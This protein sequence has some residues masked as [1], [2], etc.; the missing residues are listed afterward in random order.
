[1]LCQW[2][3]LNI[4]CAFF[5]LSI[6]GAMVHDKWSWAGQMW[7]FAACCRC[8]EERVAAPWDE[9]RWSW[10]HRNS[11]ICLCPGPGC[12]ST[13]LHAVVPYIFHC[14]RVAVS[15]C[16]NRL[17]CLFQLSCESLKTSGLSQICHGYLSYV[18]SF[19]SDISEWYTI[20][21]KGYSLV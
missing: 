13:V 7:R 4:R 10:P 8:C 20:M 15:D 14:L 2:H 17:Q 21:E 9:P 1:M 12:V 18:V 19:G 16:L 3:E 11:Y 6:S 5:L